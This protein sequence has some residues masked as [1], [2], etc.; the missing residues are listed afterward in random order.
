MPGDPPAA[1]SFDFDDPP[2]AVRLRAGAALFAA[3][4]HRAAARAWRESSAAARADAAL[5]AGLAGYATAVV[6]AGDRDW[7]GATAA[8]RRVRDRLDDCPDGAR[9]V[10][11]G[12]LR[13][14]LAAL[15]RDPVRVE[16]AA[17]VPVVVDGERPRLDALTFPAAGVAARALAAT[18]DA[19]SEG[20]HRATVE[21]AVEYATRD[22]AAGDAGSP[23][24]GL[25]LEYLAGPRG[26][27]LDRLSALIDRRA[28]REA[29]VDGLFE[30]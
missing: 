20:D 1:S 22:L 2:L 24:P 13:A 30:E 27:V 10:R 16:R 15:A 19:G 28:R 3:G 11:V 9:G 5:F 21:R 12:R 6:R 23:F 18:I 25:V 17:P 7:A 8:A 14:E 4:R 26:V 29:D